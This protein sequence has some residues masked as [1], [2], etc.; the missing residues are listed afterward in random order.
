MK[1]RL[2][3]KLHIGEFMGMETVLECSFMECSGSEKCE[4]FFNTIVLKIEQMGLACTGSSRDG[5]LRFSIY[6][7][8]SRRLNSGDMEEL[9]SFVTGNSQVSEF[10]F[11]DLHYETI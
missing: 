8:N 7:E 1:K 10:S 4:D 11:S 2:R 3:K 5:R 9:R 6:G